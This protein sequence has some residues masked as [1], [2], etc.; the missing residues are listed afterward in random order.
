M[1]KIRTLH[2]GWSRVV[3]FLIYDTIRHLQYTKKKKK[4]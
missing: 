1:C 3:K 2:R 4:Q